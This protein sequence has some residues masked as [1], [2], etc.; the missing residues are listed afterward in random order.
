[1]N[2]INGWGRY[3]TVQGYERFSEDLETISQDALLM[4]GL[5]RSYGDA[6][7]PP[8]E[9]QTVTNSTLADRLIAFDPETG[10]L[11]AE[12]GFSLFDLNRLFPPRGWATPVSPGTQY[13]T[14]G[15]MVASDVHGK[16]HHVKGCFGEHVRSLR[17]RVADGRVLEVTDES[18]PELFRAT[19]GG[20]GLTGHI[21]EVEVQLE[22]IPSAWIWGESEQVYGLDELVANL[23]ASSVEWPFTM[24]WVDSMKRG[25]Q[26]GRGIVMRGRWAEPH[27]APAK[28][29]T[30]RTGPPVPIDLPSWLLN[31]FTISAF[32]TLY[33]RKHGR[34]L[35]Q[36]VIHPWTFTYPLDAIG[37]WN[38]IYGRRGF[39]QYQC[40]MPVEDDPSV[41]RRFFEV[42]TSSG[43]ASFLTVVKDCGPEGKGMMSF[44]KPGIS[45]A[46][47]LP[48]H[49]RK[50]Q[51][52]IDAL[53][54]VVIA[55][56]GRIYLTKDALTR[57][58]H[59]RAME[60][61]LDAWNAVRR[62]WDPDGKIRSAQSVRL[63]GDEA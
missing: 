13:V 12:A 5:G 14:L 26:M 22:A 54:E 58:A 31:S 56:S 1:M 3:P 35:K 46:L 25:A 63:F 40:V 43:G 50:T 28:P 33:F 45:I 9:G 39:A 20:M 61:R 30:P 47:D 27:E 19:L 18:E 8:L 2:K 52:T 38:R 55:A 7:L 59:F 21:L 11:R 57:P 10:V 36:G 53:N 17:M 23:R 41:V 60:Q 37:S 48:M 34:K 42:M 29:P 51:A 49:D 44:P 16:N 4:R 32:N 15:G 62:K 24:S 6:S